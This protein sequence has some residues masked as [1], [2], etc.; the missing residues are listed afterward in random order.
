M[1][2]RCSRSTRGCPASARPSTIQLGLHRELRRHRQPQDGAERR[3]CGVER[4][5]SADRQRAARSGPAAHRPA[6]HGRGTTAWHRVAASG[7]RRALRLPTPRRLVARCRAA[8]SARADGAGADAGPPCASARG[9]AGANASMRSSI[10]TSPWIRRARAPDRRDPATRSDKKLASSGG[11]S[12]RRASAM[13]SAS[14]WPPR[15][16][17]RLRRPPSDGRATRA[18]RAPRANATAASAPARRLRRAAP[19][20]R[21]R[22]SASTMR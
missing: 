14:S 6:A 1:S 22:G 12:A 13:R 17:H 7:G 19:R 20:R 8:R 2:A 5:A 4:V 3:P 18:P 15:A 9:A 21:C 10:I 16:R 11:E